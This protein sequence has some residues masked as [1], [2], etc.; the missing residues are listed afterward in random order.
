[1]ADVAPEVTVV[2]R[3]V[4]VMDISKAVRGPQPVVYD[5]IAMIH[6]EPA[7]VFLPPYKK[8]DLVYQQGS[9]HVVVIDESKDLGPLTV[10]S[11]SI[12]LPIAEILKLAQNIQQQK[13]KEAEAVED[14]DHEK[15][16]D[17]V[18]AH[19]DD[20]EDGVQV[21]DGDANKVV[22]DD[23]SGATPENLI[24][25]IKFIKANDLQ[26]QRPW[27]VVWNLFCCMQIAAAR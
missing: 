9:D 2:E 13:I 5:R 23:F 3:D 20:H 16:L 11:Q 24:Q 19:F 25:L 8:G 26:A 27:C 10:K 12:G 4:S 1:M 7:V 18:L 14:V 6:Y 17:D 21:L 15:L 22:L